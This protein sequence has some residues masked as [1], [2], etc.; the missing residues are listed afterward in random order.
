ML[1]N[2]GDE[3]RR[4]LLVGSLPYGDEASAMARAYELA[5]DRLMALPDGEIGERS[6][7]YPRTPRWRVSRYCWMRSKRRGGGNVDIASAC[8]LGRRDAETADELI[9][10]CAHLARLKP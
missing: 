2:F 6:D 3:A 7:Q 10:R 9:R 5:G 4:V 8:G 1:M